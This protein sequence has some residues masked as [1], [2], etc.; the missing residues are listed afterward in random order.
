MAFCG[1]PLGV[2]EGS[3]RSEYGLVYKLAVTY[4]LLQTVGDYNG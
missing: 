2:N 3:S 4:F 1:A